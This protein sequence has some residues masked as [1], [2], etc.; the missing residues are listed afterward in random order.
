[1]NMKKRIPVERLE[2]IEKKFG[3]S[4]NASAFL[5]FLIEEDST[6]EE[7]ISQI[8]LEVSGE[9]VADVL[10]TDIII[11]A[12]AYNESGS[13]VGTQKAMPPIYKDDFIGIASF[14]MKM[15][16]LPLYEEETPVRVRVYPT[17]N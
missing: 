14:Q 16:S 10:N 5:D 1:M 7:C 15:F 3:V 12:V 2:V 4:L 13:I 8:H 6:G 9:I 17:R 11:V